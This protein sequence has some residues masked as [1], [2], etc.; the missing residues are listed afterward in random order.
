MEFSLSFREISK[1]L[2]KDPTTISK[3][4]RLHRM[5]DI[6]PKRIFNNPHNFCTKR[7]RCRKTNAC[8]KLFICD[9]KCSSCMKCNQVCKDFV[10]EECSRL[11]RTSYPMGRAKMRWPHQFIS[12]RETRRNDT[13]YACFRKVWPGY[14]PGPAAQIYWAWHCKPYT[15]AFKIMRQV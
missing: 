3:E 5:D 14:A 2:C 13:I 1:F 10:K 12:S 6:H 4:I 7:F 11:N 8:N 9:T 15:F